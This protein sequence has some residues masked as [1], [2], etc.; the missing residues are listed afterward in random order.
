M[1]WM[2]LARPLGKVVALLLIATGAQLAG[3][4][5]LELASDTLSSFGVEFDLWNLL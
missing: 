1:I 2:L 4:P 3:F 5:I